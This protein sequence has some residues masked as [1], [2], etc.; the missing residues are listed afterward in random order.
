MLNV[1]IDIFKKIIKMK[2]LHKNFQKEKNVRIEKRN[3]SKF[4]FFVEKYYL[5]NDVFEKKLFQ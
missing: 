4:T 5:R 1:K 2:I 3:L